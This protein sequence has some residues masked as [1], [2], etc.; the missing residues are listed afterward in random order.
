VTFIVTTTNIAA[1]SAITLNG[2]PAGVTLGT[3]TTTGNSTTMT[4]DTTDATP[5]GNHSLTVTIDGVTSPNFTLSVA[6]AGAVF[7][8]G[9]TVT[10]ASGATTITTNGGT[11][12]MS[13][14]VLPNDATNQTV[15]WSITAGAGNAT[16]SSA[17]LLTAT[18]NG[19]VTV[20]ATANDG[21]NVFGEATITISGQTTQIDSFTV[22][23][24]LNGGNVGGNTANVVI[25]DVVSGTNVTPPTP[26]RAGHTFNGWTP[27]GAYNNVTSDRAITAQWTPVGGTP[28]NGGGNA[29]NNQGGNQGQDR[30]NDRNG[31]GIRGAIATVFAPAERC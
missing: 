23:F 8:T 5:Q 11:L 29:Q 25:T 19:T 16:I 26:T 3:T 2:A 18:A 17:G 4:I 28:S 31:G 1:G 30:D 13:A 22:T 15:T 9:I 27:A 21:S 24:N 6:P 7:V 14:N 20:R 10:G 12:Q